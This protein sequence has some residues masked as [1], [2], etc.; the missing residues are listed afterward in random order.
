[1]TRVAFVVSTL[2][3]GVG[4]AWAQTAEIRACVDKRGRFV[5]VLEGNRRCAKRQTAV[6]WNVEGPPGPTGAPGA[7]GAAG[8]HDRAE[9]RHR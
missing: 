5:R 8:P 6:T 1:M 9:E 2:A 3:I 7:Q 4:P